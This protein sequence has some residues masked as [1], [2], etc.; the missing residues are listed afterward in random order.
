[1]A[2]LMDCLGMTDA[3]A[4]R[5]DYVPKLPGLVEKGE[6]D[7]NKFDEGRRWTHHYYGDATGTTRVK[8]FGKKYAVNQKINRDRERW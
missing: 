8:A 5:Q 1:M 4:R 6:H 7:P 2:P 3:A